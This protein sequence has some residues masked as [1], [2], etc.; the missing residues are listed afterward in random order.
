MR[1][2]I[3]ARAIPTAR[4]LRLRNSSY[5]MDKPTASHTTR[6]SRV[7]PRHEDK[8]APRH[9]IGRRKFVTA[10]SSHPRL[11]R[12]ASLR[13]EHH[14]S[15]RL[16]WWSPQSSSISSG[17]VVFPKAKNLR[18]IT[19]NISFFCFLFLIKNA[20]LKTRA[21][22]RHHFSN[23]RL[24]SRSIWRQWRCWRSSL[25]R[26]CAAGNRGNFHHSLVCDWKTWTARGLNPTPHSPL[27]LT[28]LPGQ[29]LA[30]W[31]SASCRSPQ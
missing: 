18:K 27:S 28:G 5:A 31:S 29:G 4:H 8:S 16:K 26:S 6:P 1:A 7:E 20:T 19:L 2:V 22:I 10:G 13:V 11:Q 24:D 14:W 15:E 17:A 9:A 3:T 30:A 21:K 23:H 12:V 25:D